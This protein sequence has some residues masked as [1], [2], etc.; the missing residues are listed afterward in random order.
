MK[1]DTFVDFI[2]TKLFTLQWLSVLNDPVGLI[3]MYITQYWLPSRGC[4][5]LLQCYYT[6]NGDLQPFQIDNT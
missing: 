4:V 3:Y 1:I 6:R 5:S 2:S